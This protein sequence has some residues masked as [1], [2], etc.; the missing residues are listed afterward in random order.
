MH[1]GGHRINIFSFILYRILMNGTLLE[2][3]PNKIR[4]THNYNMSV[5]VTE[6]S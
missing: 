3:V 5:P 4:W 2:W 1:A 6:M